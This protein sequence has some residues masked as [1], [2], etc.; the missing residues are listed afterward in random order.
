MS[1]PSSEFWI[2]AKAQLAE[3]PKKRRLD[4]DKRIDLDK[5]DVVRANSVAR[6]VGKGNYGDFVLYNGIP[7]SRIPPAEVLMEASIVVYNSTVRPYNVGTGAR[8]T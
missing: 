4:S 2:V 3:A 6:L 5:H 7:G 1:K 8:C